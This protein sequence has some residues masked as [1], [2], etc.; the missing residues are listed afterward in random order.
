M[1]NIECIGSKTKKR[2]KR[3]LISSPKKLIKLPKAKRAKSKKYHK[4]GYRVSAQVHDTLE[5]N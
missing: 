3:D 1:L 2:C 5:L 4:K